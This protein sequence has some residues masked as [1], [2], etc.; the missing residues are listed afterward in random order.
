MRPHDSER[1]KWKR[2]E[3]GPHTAFPPVRAWSSVSTQSAPGGIR[4][5]NLLIRKIRRR[6]SSGSAVSPRDSERWLTSGQGCI[7]WGHVGVSHVNTARCTSGE[8]APVRPV[9]T[10]RVGDY[11]QFALP[12]VWPLSSK[13]VISVVSSGRYCRAS[14]LPVLGARWRAARGAR[15][16]CWAA[17]CESSRPDG[18]S[19]LPSPWQGR[20]A[21]TRQRAFLRAD[22]GTRHPKPIGQR[23]VDN[24]EESR[25]ETPSGIRQVGHASSGASN[26]G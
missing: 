14:D 13:P 5:P 23:M 2:N 3:Q 4:T 25:H 20:A 16:F 12:S 18:V 26:G 19:G 17:R 7:G 6:Q 21:R 10:R 22:H 1:P 15:S 24:L 8:L 9:P 11:S